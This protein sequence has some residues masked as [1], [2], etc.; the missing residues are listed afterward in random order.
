MAWRQRVMVPAFVAFFIF[1]L[2]SKLDETMSEVVAKGEWPRKDD[3]LIAGLNTT[4]L[5]RA[6]EAAIQK[7]IPDLDTGAARSAFV[8]NKYPPLTSFWLDNDPRRSFSDLKLRLFTSSEPLNETTLGVNDAKKLENPCGD[9]GFACLCPNCP[10]RWQTIVYVV[11]GQSSK[12]WLHHV[13]SYVD[14]NG[15]DVALLR[16]DPSETIVQLH[17]PRTLRPKR[18]VL[19]VRTDDIRRH[20]GRTAAAV[21]AWILDNAKARR[22][23]D[24][25]SSSDDD[26]FRSSG[27]LESSLDNLLNRLDTARLAARVDSSL[28]NLY[29]EDNVFLHHDDDDI[30]PGHASFSEDAL[31]HT[32]RLRT[33]LGYSVLSP[34]AN[35]NVV[36]ASR[37]EGDDEL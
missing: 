12:D 3:V 17:K 36:T 25:L 19:V 15:H 29:G 5:R 26:E 14:G 33:L 4:L 18:F 21:V 27:G 24:V 6:L 34:V 1:R 31:D 8:T 32:N 9:D 16:V 35:Y 20:P 7:P 10:A 22:D 23:L 13:S 2:W 30:S 11:S 28:R 37:S